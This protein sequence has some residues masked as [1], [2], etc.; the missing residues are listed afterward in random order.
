[1]PVPPI[2]S[3]HNPRVKLVRKLHE[4]KWRRREGLF[5]IEGKALVEEAFQAGWPIEEVMAT[6][7]WLSRHPWPHEMPFTQVSD[8][9]MEA[10][11]ALETPEGIL[12]L[13]RL[14]RESALPAVHDRSLWLV[15]DGLRDPGNLGTMIRTA[16]AAGAD[17]VLVGPGTVDPF[18][19]KTV[20]ASMGSIFHLAVV[21]VPD[22]EA[23][24]DA[25]FRQGMR[26]LALV[27][28][29][30]RSV[31]DED[32]TGPLALWVGNEATGLDPRALAAADVQVAIP[33]P[34]RAES[35]N[36]AAAVA[37]CLFEAVRQRAHGRPR[38]GSQARKSD[39]G[40]I[41]RQPD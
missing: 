38:E 21:A 25:T 37:V 3:V 27:P 32:L 4:P 17:A 20:R 35:L 30:R 18:A 24:H 12:A 26:W 16:D 22:L 19:P 1:M 7:G 10:M 11:S 2:T 39:R 36:A 34:G 5:L 31:Y 23:A 33:M 13:A 40:G 6:A 9:V 41:V 8:H 29:A 14:P 15:A 28:R